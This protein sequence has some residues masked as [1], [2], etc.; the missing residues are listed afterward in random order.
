MG[1]VC[2]KE[3]KP[4]PE[5]QQVGDTN[6]ATGPKG[7]HS[8]Q[9][10][11]NSCQTKGNYGEEDAEDGDH[12]STSHSP[13]HEA[14][15]HHHKQKHKHK[16][17]HH[18]Y[19]NDPDYGAHS[20]FDNESRS[21]TKRS[22]FGKHG[23]QD[24]GGTAHHSHHHP[25]HPPVHI[26]YLEDPKD[27]SENG[28]W[29]DK[30]AERDHHLEHVGEGNEKEHKNHEDEMATLEKMGHDLDVKVRQMEVYKMEAQAAQSAMQVVQHN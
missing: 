14:T 22:K 23:P 29:R 28:V 26:K 13:D 20:N 1:A 30:R 24:D 27:D 3:V 7:P 19:H 2:K 11:P 21:H 15:A 6:D 18:D 5:L 25:S 8:K 9:T 10:A 4:H 12:T 16:H 17:H